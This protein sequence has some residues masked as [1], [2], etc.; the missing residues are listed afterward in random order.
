MKILATADWHIRDKD[1]DEIEKCLNYLIEVAKKERPNLIIHAGDI[2]DSRDVK[3]D[4]ISAKLTFHIFSELAEIAP[5]C[6][7][8]GTPLHEGYATES[9]V[10]AS[11]I[12][13]NVWVSSQPEQ[14]RLHNGTLTSLEYVG[15]DK[16]DLILSML[17]TPTKQF[18]QGTDEEISNA[19][20]PIFA[21]FGAQAAQYDCPH[22]LVGHW[23][24]RGAAISDTQVMV[25]RDIEIGTDQ[26]ALAKAHLTCLGHIHKAQ[27]IGENMFYSGSIYRTKHG[28][29]EA[30]GFYI[31]EI[32]GG[33]IETPE[34]KGVYS[35]SRFIETPARQRLTL[36]EDFSQGNDIQD[37][38]ATLRSLDPGEVKGASIKVE[39]K[40][41]EDETGAIDKQGIEDFY[42]A[43]GAESVEVHITAIPRENVRSERILKL[44]TLREKVQERAA[45][46]CETV[47]ETI[48]EK[49]DLLETMSD[50][51]VLAHVANGT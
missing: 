10:Y 11:N 44:E 19:L 12:D 26:I 38:D 30:K 36:K 51:E 28:E 5:I 25:G 24:V 29:T 33:I 15:R 46:S 47:P 45:L 34:G 39:L 49:A 35:G 7:I 43:A 17:P 6:T 40:A 20:T 22:I 23:T 3:L 48:L 32:L 21:G 9:L 16:T 13:H 37:L 18:M 41:W 31:H 42:R 8:L 2:F 50:D 27:K 14:L 4:S 1:I